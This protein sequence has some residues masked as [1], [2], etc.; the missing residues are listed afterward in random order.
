MFNIDS[1]LDTCIH[2]DVSSEVS[3]LLGIID[4]IYLKPNYNV[5]TDLVPTGD[6]T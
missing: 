5:V 3:L 6:H 2:H 4:C 1:Y